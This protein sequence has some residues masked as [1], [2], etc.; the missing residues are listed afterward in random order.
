MKHQM[1]KYTRW[2]QRRSRLIIVPAAMLLFLLSAQAQSSVVLPPIG[3]GGGGQYVARCPQGQHLAGFELRT[4][5]WVDAIRPLCVT[6]Y[7]PNEVGPPVPGG[8]W[9]GGNGGGPGQLVCPSDTPIV[10][11]MF[12][13]AEGVQ[14][15]TVNS[16]HLWCG[17]AATTQ[18]RS[19]LPNAA[20]DATKA[21]HESDLLFNTDTLKHIRETQN[22]PAGLV[23]VGIN[24]RSG[25]WLDAVGLMCGVP[26]LTPR[27]APPPEAP[28]VKAI[29]RVKA[30]TTPGTTPAPPR[31]ICN[32]AREARER[33][34]P[35]APGLE[36]QCL[37]TVNALAA[38]GEAVAN[39][40]PY[41]LALRNQQPAGL[42][43][44]GFDIGMAAAEGQ[45]APGAG[46]QSIHDS[47]SPAEQVGFNA[48]VSFSLERNRKL[49]GN[50]DAALAARGKA[51]ANQD[52]LA[53]ALRNQ[54][55]DEPSRRGFDIGM[56]AAE[57]QTAPG[58]GKQ[59]LLESL[60]PA[61][62]GGFSIAVS[63]SLERN[64]NAD[65]ARKGAAIAKVDRIVAAARAAE[66]DVFYQLGFDIA[67]GIFGDPSR[68]GAGH[69]SEGSGS[70]AIRDS[71]SA[72]GQRGFN[73]AVKLHLSQ[74]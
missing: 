67:T 49:E 52:P 60:E 70:K 46:K 57:G 61:Q 64:R 15:I 13:W 32:V 37:A 25:D 21:S 39:Q 36:A 68:G 72:A 23:A 31:P 10:I 22:C 33:N 11:G 19:E 40:D 1:M 50:K 18:N 9:F 12:V 27:A 54:Q 53:V 71:L 29:G 14:I 4:G 35:A 3:G 45:T 59:R 69:T 62:R 73:D 34:S 30:P 74:H 24:G 26:T 43:R 42:A 16:I 51:I 63:F 8:I 6:A 20:F 38:R 17:V 48:A 66:A 41:A 7:G 58:S 56:A 28:G 2:L 65:F 5:G 47:L 44:R 55:P